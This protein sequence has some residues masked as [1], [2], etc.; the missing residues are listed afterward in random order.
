MEYTYTSYKQL[1]LSLKNNGYDM[2]RFCDVRERED[3]HAIIR[4]DID[5]DL[6]EAEKI[7]RIENEMGVQSTYFVLISSDYYNL[8]SKTNMESTNTILNLGH[9]IGLH[10]DITAYGPNIPIEKIGK[11]LRRE[12]SIFESGFNIKIKSFSWHIPRND[13]IGVHLDVADEMELFNAY[14]PAFYY[15]YKYVS[16]SMMRWR[17]PIEDY[18][19]SKKYKKLQI[20]THPI[21]YRETQDMIDVEILDNNHKK[22]SVIESRYLNTIRPGFYIDE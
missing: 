22:K 6:Q 1:L 10:F 8:F 15:G 2:V 18:I 12:I 17:E 16:D 4:H 20:L 14:D 19:K 3:C 5:M 7:A 21:W 13:L 11:A 9:E